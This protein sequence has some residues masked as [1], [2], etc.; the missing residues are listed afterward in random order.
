MHI[1]PGPVDALRPDAVPLQLPLRPEG[2][3]RTSRRIE[4]LVLS[5]DVRRDRRACPADLLSYNRGNCVRCVS[6]GQKSP[7][8][9]PEERL[10]GRP[11]I[12]DCGVVE[13]VNSREPR[14]LREQENYGK[15]Q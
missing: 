15:S 10:E 11:E 8:K 1:V 3:R 5:P 13:K 12:G 4:G 9:H 7:E 14:E 6:A 2:L